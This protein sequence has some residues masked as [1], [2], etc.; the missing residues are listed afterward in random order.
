MTNHRTRNRN[1]RRTI[2]VDLKPD[3]YRD[4]VYMSERNDVRPSTLAGLLLRHA[5]AETLAAAGT[6]KP[7]A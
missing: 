1:G 5:I 2:T 3:A 4:L 6:V 7:T